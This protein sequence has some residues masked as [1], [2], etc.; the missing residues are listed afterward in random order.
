MHATVGVS[1]SITAGEIYLCVG[2]YRVAALLMVSNG[3]YTVG[4]RPCSVL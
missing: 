3:L 2:A 1:V 4:K